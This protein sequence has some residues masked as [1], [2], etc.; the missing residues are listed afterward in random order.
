MMKL[1]QLGVALGVLG[2]MLALMGLFPGVM[3]FNPTPGVGAI[4][5]FIILVGFFLL[6]VGAIIYVKDAFYDQQPSNLVQQ[7]GVR[8]AWTGLIFCAMSG[9]ADFLGFGSH[10]PTATSDVVLG[11]LQLIGV[12][13]GF[14]LSSIGV[15]IFA[16]GGIPARDN[17]D[18]SKTTKI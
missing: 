18:T 17:R 3:G 15:I 14:L 11:E 1:T 8:L 4:Q 13:G 7:V 9:L 5:F 10:T 2:F 12:I 6:I 16:A